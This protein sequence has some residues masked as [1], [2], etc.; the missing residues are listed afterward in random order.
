MLDFPSGP[1]V[2]NLPCNARDTSLIPGP[3]RSHMPLSKEACMPQR[4]SPCALESVLCNKSEEKPAH[5]N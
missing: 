5:H 2:K 3:G 4:L 1:V